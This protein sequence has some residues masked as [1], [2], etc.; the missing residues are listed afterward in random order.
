M[1]CARCSARQE[2]ASFRAGDLP[3][4]DYIMCLSRSGLCSRNGLGFL[5]ELPR[6]ATADMIHRAAVMTVASV[7]RT[8]RTEG[9]GVRAQPPSAIA[10]IT[11]TEPAAKNALPTSHGLPSVY[12]DH[13]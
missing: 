7:A 10:A 8:V 12:R 3:A 1:A 13:Q 6:G 11:K 4:D 5:P 9:V 2:L